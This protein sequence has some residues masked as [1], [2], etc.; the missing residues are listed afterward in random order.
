MKQ[1]RRDKAWTEFVTWCEARRLRPLPAHSWTIAAYA[2]W[3]EPRHR[4]AAIVKRVRAIARAHVLHCE[5]SADRHPTVSRTLRIIEARE[6]ARRHAA[7]L[8]RADDFVAGGTRPAPLP[9]QRA[10]RKRSLRSTPRLVRRR[11][12]AP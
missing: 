6:R 5:K 1:T 9:A 4:H 8:F 3:C 2:R 7:A 12:P 10:A 11:T